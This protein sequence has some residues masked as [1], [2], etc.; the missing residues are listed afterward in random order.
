MS[1][2]L[3]SRHRDYIPSFRG[4]KG[5][6]LAE[7]LEGQGESYVSSHANAPSVES[8][9]CSDGEPSRRP[10]ARRRPGLAALFAVAAFATLLFSAS[11][12]AVTYNHVTS[13]PLSELNTGS[14][15][16]ASVAVNQLSGDLYVAS[17]GGGEGIALGPDGSVKRFS[18]SGAPLSCALSPPP[19]HPAGLAINPGNGDIYS[20]NLG[21]V[22]SDSELRT[23]PAGCGTELPVNSGTANTV[24]GSKEL[25]AVSMAHPLQVG[26]GV[27]GDDIPTAVLTG[28][29]GGDEFITNVSLLSGRL[30]VGQMITATG[31][32]PAVSGEESVTLAGCAPSCAAPTEL[33]LS[34]KAANVTTIPGA[35]ITARTTVKAV[36]EGAGT[37]E[38]SNP[39]EEDHTGASI[40]GT[41]WRVEAVGLSPIGQAAADAS[42]DLYWPN[43][44]AG[45]L[46][47][48][49]PWGQGLIEGG[50]PFAMNRPAAVARDA[51]GNLYVS[52][53]GS[54]PPSA[55]YTCN[56]NVAGK[57]VKLKPNGEAFPEGGPIGPESVFGGLTSNVTTVAVDPKTGNVY[58]GRN[59]GAT[60]K[61]EVYGPGGTKLAETSEGIFELSTIFPPSAAAALYN[62]LAVDED[63]G[64]IYGAD[65]GHEKVQAFENTSPQ[66][67]LA[68]TVTGSAPGEVQC[69]GSAS[70]CLA[71]YDE[72]QEVILEAVGGSGFEKWTGGSGSAEA[73]ND[74]TQTSCTFILDADSSIE[75]E[76]AAGPVPNPLDLT[77][78]GS[79]SGTFTCKV[80]GGSEEACEASYEEGTSV[81]VL[82]H[83]DTGSHFV[84]FNAENGGEC[85]GTDP[86][87]CTVS[88]SAARSVN[89]KFDLNAESFSESATGPGSLECEDANAG[90]G[91]GTCASSY[92][93]GH[94][95]K[96]KA[97]PD[98][99]AHLES[100]SGSGSAS[101]A[102]TGSECS[103]EITEASGAS[104]T[105]ALD[106]EPLTIEELGAGTGEV[107]C[108]GGSCAGPW[109]Y[110]DSIEVTATPTGGSS[111]GA[112][113]GTGSAS[114][115]TASPCSFEITEASSV[116][117][118]FV[119][120]G[121]AELT[122]VKGG[123]GEGTVESVSPSTEIDCGST[124]SGTFG[125]GETVTLKATAQ[126]PG[127][128]FLAWSGTCAPTGLS[129][130]EVEVQ[131]GGTTVTATF[132]A[133]PVISFEPEGDNCEFGGTKIEYAGSTEYIC[134]GKIGEDGEAGKE[135][136]IRSFTANGEPS[137]SPCDGNGGIEVE[138]EGEPSTLK[139]LCNGAVGPPGESVAV[140]VEPPGVNCAFGGLKLTSETGI[141]FVC[142]GAPGP[143]GPSG[144]QGP[145]GSNGSDG[146]R[147]PSGAAGPQGPQGPQGP[148][149][150]VKVVCKVKQQGNHVK[151]TCKV[152][153]GK[154]KK[155]ARRHLRWRLMKRGHAMSH[156]SS[157]G[158]LR[159]NLK[160]LRPGRYVLHVNGRGTAIVVPA[161]HG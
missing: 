160:N 134:N 51:Q 16:T 47:K 73:C 157:K 59:C 65:P 17:P 94:T 12:Q 69:N 93:Y 41:A 34:A 136:V 117:V 97:V 36:N 145:G 49:A 148:A 43:R 88:M 84:E 131:P 46:Q 31:V 39:V 77:S 106:E 150:K 112:L 26:Q 138:I 102:C 159:L 40:S 139:I 124:C 100:L 60:F 83:A 68:T 7:G 63:T 80:N 19:S 92:P 75:A 57:L 64:T 129:E 50:F 147:G 123:N 146:A 13:G 118:T 103:F 35:T 152:Q 78:T 10:G 119:P 133:V 71:S 21:R 72:G 5:K 127:S 158:T 2:F 120:P 33:E 116:S 1:V 74:S 104:A 137:G 45:Q 28:D 15:T 109:H 11:A 141:A 114:S 6:R 122:V 38:L 48:F 153:Q 44:T 25:T 155:R 85:S 105:F 58:V 108:N 154:N 4:R 32:G 8:D 23:Y 76:Y 52:T 30:A 9:R 95:I 61:I 3:K 161:R 115:C 91:F 18:S 156:G 111:L 90:G 20:V 66:K 121:A 24:E 27:S 62:Q 54:T 132:A 96:V 101:G 144:A 67:T 135:I 110:G 107:K 81:Q 140:T 56:N 42:G 86:E 98:T 130:C 70:A 143:Q 14:Q 142:N 113:S 151:V 53:I 89:A 87:G 128:I 29:I 79:G 99:G 22:A 37:V 149:G 55:G 125:A 82:P 126:A